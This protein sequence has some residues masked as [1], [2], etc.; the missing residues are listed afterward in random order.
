[1]AALKGEQAELIS[2]PPPPGVDLASYQALVEGDYRTAI[3]E[4]NL[5][6]LIA[7]ADQL[8]RL[9]DTE[10]KVQRSGAI[11]R[12]IKA[13]RLELKTR[14]KP[15]DRVKVNNQ[16]WNPND[17]GKVG[18][19]IAYPNCKQLNNEHV[20]AEID[21]MLLDGKPFGIYFCPE[22]IDL[23]EPEPAPPEPDPQ[24]T[25]TDFA[26]LR[27][28]RLFSANPGCIVGNVLRV[29]Q[30]KRYYSGPG[31]EL[32][33]VESATA[34]QLRLAENGA[35][36]GKTNRVAKDKVWCIPT[37][38]H[39]DKA[40][41]LNRQFHKALSD[42]AVFL[43]DLG[44]YE[45][46]LEKAGG[47][48]KAAN[49]LTPTAIECPDP[50]KDDRDL[51]MSNCWEVYPTK[52]Q[53]VKLAAH[54]P[55]MLKCFWDWQEEGA[56][57]GL[58][59]QNYFF[60]CPDDATW[61]KYLKTR[62]AAIDAA[63]AMQAYLEELGTYKEAETDGRY[64]RSQESAGA[65]APAGS[66]DDGRDL[67]DHA[68]G[69][70]LSDLSA[71]EQHDL[72]RQV[73]T[74]PGPLSGSDDTPPEP[75]RVAETPATCQL[76][77]GDRVRVLSDAFGHQGQVTTIINEQYNGWWLTEL[78]PYH[79]R[80]LELVPPEPE[81]P[82]QES[83]PDPSPAVNTGHQ[84]Q[85]GD[86][87]RGRTVGG[88]QVLE[89]VITSLGYTYCTLNNDRD[90]G[91]VL[92]ESLEL[93]RADA[94]SDAN[95][96][97]G[98]YIGLT[99]EELADAI[100]SQYR[101]KNLGDYIG[102]ELKSARPWWT[103]ADIWEIRFEDAREV[104]LKHKEH[105]PSW[106]FEIAKHPE[107]RGNGD[108]FEYCTRAIAHLDRVQVELAA[109]FSHEAPAP[110]P[111]AEPQQSQPTPPEPE[112]PQPAAEPE[113]AQQLTIPEPSTPNPPPTLAEVLHRLQVRLAQ[114]LAG[115][116]NAAEKRM[117]QLSKREL[118]KTSFSQLRE[119][120][121]AK[122]SQIAN[123]QKKMRRLLAQFLRQQRPEPQG[124][125]CPVLFFY[126]APGSRVRI[127]VD[128]AEF[129]VTRHDLFGVL[130]K[131][132]E[133]KYEGCEAGYPLSVVTHIDGIPTG[134]IANRGEVC[135]N[136]VSPEQAERK[137]LLAECDRI[138][139]EGEVAP[140]GC[141][142]EGYKVT[143]KLADG[144]TKRF[145]YWRMKADRA[146]FQKRN[147]AMTKSLHLGTSADAS[148]KDWAARLGRRRHI[149]ALESQLD[150]IERQ[151]QE[152]KT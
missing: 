78:K 131:Y 61:E 128:P 112:A 110:Q 71:V 47:I 117:R 132:V 94:I 93:I 34:H 9:K 137:A 64:L 150:K 135:I 133:G 44:N 50:A 13:Q 66:P 90:G 11:H 19:V 74:A 62:K 14:F 26:A 89:G 124:D 48:K 42:L 57:P 85:Y 8:E 20:K 28:E 102:P 70:S 109:V 51:E 144:S 75:E 60:P 114:L 67:R 30:R 122:R 25:P 3:E 68:G 36:V 84:W 149:N 116:H 56:E 104:H 146:M 142:M 120:E 107:L 92:V 130:L 6:T 105:R 12:A 4:S 21:G 152:E 108:L 87:V 147:G 113:Q 119:E 37:E 10:P 99:W 5:P 69:D 41:D 145:D 16:H 80:F 49:P 95:E 38:A 79:E 138:R 76:K 33:R 91:R 101:I 29:G 136:P 81:E 59:N 46:C 129:E 125:Y 140:P 72:D 17:W 96:H 121:I 35:Q 98:V 141:W 22:A 31:V 139:K 24:A 126:P 83:L 15:G 40:M 82:E 127:C 134:I 7:A 111:T 27:E 58:T 23:L 73:G 54:T 103:I 123:L 53:R 32:L 86:L 52:P 106:F 143:K 151:L 1:M 45:T 55:K 2:V 100:F 148:Y 43:Y 39:W 77:P 63:K 118:A 18:T 115:A 88:G 97:L 65:P